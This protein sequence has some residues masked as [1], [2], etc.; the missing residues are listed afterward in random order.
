MTTTCIVI[1]PVLASVLIALLG[2]RAAR[3]AVAVADTVSSD[4][5]GK[6]SL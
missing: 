1:D 4:G 3:D 5:D 6:E 2:P